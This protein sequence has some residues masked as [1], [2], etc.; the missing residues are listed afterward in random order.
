MQA[1]DKYQPFKSAGNDFADSNPIF[2]F[3]FYQ[4]FYESAIDIVKDVQDPGERDE[5]RQEIQECEA[6]MKKMQGGSKIAMDKE[7]N[8]VDILEYT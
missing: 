3:Y 7:Q 4:Y 8:M 2:A 1:L 6:L 5:I